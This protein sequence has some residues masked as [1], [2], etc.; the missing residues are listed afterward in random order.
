MHYGN[1]LTPIKHMG[2]NS[3]L[4]RQNVCFHEKNEIL[5][6]VNNTIEGKYD[7]EEYQK[8]I[9][10]LITENGNNDLPPTEQEQPTTEE[11]GLKVEQI[12]GL[13][14]GVVLLMAIITLLIPKRRKR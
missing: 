3:N 10:Q 2:S 9:D 11:E 8:K 6:E 4:R 13:C 14:A 5:I 12:I 7:H 1:F